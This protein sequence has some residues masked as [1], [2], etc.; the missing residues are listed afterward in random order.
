MR[1]SQNF[2]K[3]FWVTLGLKSALVMVLL[4]ESVA[5]AGLPV[6]PTLTPAATLPPTV[7]LP[8]TA[9]PLPSLT[10]VP[11]PV[12]GVLYVDAAQDLGP[13]SPL[14]YGTNYGPWLGVS[15]Q[16]KEDVVASKLSL[17]RFPAGAWGDQND[18]STRQMDLFMSLSKELGSEPMINVRLQN[19]TPQK[20]ADLVN[21]ANLAKGYNVRY[22][23]IGNEPN[24][25]VG[26][27]TIEQFNK[28]WRALALAMRAV[29]PT[30]KLIGPEISQFYVNPTGDYET[31]IVN[32]LTQFLQA[33]GDLV[34]IVSFHRYPFPRSTTAG[35][36]SIDDMRNNSREWDQLIP[37]ARAIILQTTG[38]DLPI[39]VTEVNSSWAPSIGGE[40]TM[41][42]HY[43]AIWWGD[44][45]GRMIRQK[46]EMVAQFALTGD[47]GIFSRFHPNPMYGT[48]L[49]YQ[50]FGQE[51]I[52]SASDDLDV[53]IYAAKREDGA[54]TLMLVNLSLEARDK[55]ITLAN[56][57]PG[58]SAET[59]LFD[60]THLAES[61]TPTSVGAS[62]TL[63][64]P[65]Q[66]LTLLI[67]PAQ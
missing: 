64:L 46:V 58:A 7:T 38:R 27:Y 6:P 15:L 37:N 39:A 13:I 22:W 17:I 42:S 49:M 1:F 29:D 23:G 36:P 63:S 54:L 56:F 16:I 35:P 67:V 32:W 47:F 33:N 41:D 62:T 21:Y 53:S 44:V 59:W 3:G 9:T 50:R 40:A 24:L 51:L 61:V 48:Y 4:V 43:N 34:D 65:A 20:A 30:I 10:P 28:D 45:L 57:T 52:Y 31:N 19:G 5:C 25:Y 18:I 66:S 2:R 8:P 14:I 55:E 26:G 12:P 60:P 11:T